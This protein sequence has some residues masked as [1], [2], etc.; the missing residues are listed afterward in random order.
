MPLIRVKENPFISEVDLLP[1]E[2]PEI[3]AQI[4]A[5]E[6]QIAQMKEIERKIK[7]QK[8]R[9]LNAMTSANVKS[10]TTPNGYKIT[11][12]DPTEDKTV[13]ESYFDEKALEKEDPEVYK[14][15]LKE[16]NVIKCGK[17][18]YIKITAPNKKEGGIEE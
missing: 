18:G 9:L 3:T 16:K 13:K 6:Y 4:L 17:A 14:K 10:W 15:Y 2:I 8:T 12:V 1:A 7:E 5:F 11:R